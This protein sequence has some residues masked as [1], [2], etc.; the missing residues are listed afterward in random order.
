MFHESSVAPGFSGSSGYLQLLEAWGKRPGAILSRATVER[1][2][3][4]LT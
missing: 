4:V 1:A 3:L 2:I